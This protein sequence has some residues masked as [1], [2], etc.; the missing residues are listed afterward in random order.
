MVA[1]DLLRLAESIDPVFR[2]GERHTRFSRFDKSH[3]RRSSVRIE[4]LEDTIAR[5][6]RFPAA[7][8]LDVPH[9][10]IDFLGLREPD[11]LL[12]SGALQRG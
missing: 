3:E 8:Q 4:P 6:E 1:G 10:G 7:A 9:R 12:R 5:M 2:H 11:C